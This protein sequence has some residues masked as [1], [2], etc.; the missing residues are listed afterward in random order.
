MCVFWRKAAREGG[1]RE[2][3]ARLGRERGKRETDELK[4]IGM[5]VT[6]EKRERARERESERARETERQREAERKVERWLWAVADAGAS[7]CV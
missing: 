4:H 5:Y 2:S 6:R 7:V 3:E 1:K